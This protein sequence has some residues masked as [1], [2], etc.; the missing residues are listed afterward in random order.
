[1]ATNLTKGLDYTGICVT[2]FIHDGSGR[3]LMAKRSQQTRDEQGR[4]EVG[5]GGVKFGE[6]LDEALARE[7]R[8]EYGVPILAH[9]FIGYRDVHREQNGRRSHWLAMDFKIQVDPATV[10]N[11]DP[12]MIDELG[13]FTLE[14]TPQNL[15][16][17][18]PAMFDLYRDH[19]ID[20]A[21]LPE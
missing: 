14:T 2:F 19:F 13:W 4:W 16:S 7:V 12:E 11:N 17:Q 3:F 1:M 20:V 18:V 15:H 21:Q 8:E 5:G 6:R 9:E 10:I